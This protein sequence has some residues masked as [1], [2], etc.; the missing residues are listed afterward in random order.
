MWAW[1]EFANCP[2]PQMSGFQCVLP[3]PLV[4]N[5]TSKSYPRSTES[6]ALEMG[7]AIWVLT[8]PP[9]DCDICWNL[10]ITSSDSCYFTA[11]NQVQDIRNFFQCFWVLHLLF[12]WDFIPYPFILPSLPWGIPAQLSDLYFE[13]TSSRKHCLD[14]LARLNAPES[15]VFLFVIYQIV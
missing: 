15:F 1:Y 5:A 12:S 10:R 7:P 2:L 9:G 3:R 6:E 11:H 4:R 8:H 13:V 14:C